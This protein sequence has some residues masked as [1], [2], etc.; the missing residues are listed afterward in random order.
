MTRE[1]Q[2]APVAVITG[3]GTGIGRAAAIRF[4]QRG[5]NVV[6]AGRREAP[7][8]ETASACRTASA[9]CNA[10][11]VPTDVTDP[12]Q[13]KRLIDQ[14]IEHFGRL[15][16][17][18]NNAG[19]G[20][21]GPAKN[22]SPDDVRDSLI[23]NAAS[24]AWLIHFAWPTFEKQREG[25][26]INVTSMAAHDPFPGLYAYGAGKAACESLTRSIRNER[27]ELN[28][29]AFSVAPGAVET[30]LLRSYFDESVV[31]KSATMTPDD[32]AQVIV[33]CALGEYDDRDGEA[34]LVREPLKQI[35]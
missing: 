12:D 18:V 14:T 31:P 26:V 30:D 32:I 17:L 6:L 9:A 5:W 22:A 15:D 19:G 34:I 27:G 20:P 10:L 8:H 28:I 13:C 16:A 7:L 21:V 35:T 23:L 25:C 3:G 2:S 24:P 29:R 11:C 1:G 4:A 33:G